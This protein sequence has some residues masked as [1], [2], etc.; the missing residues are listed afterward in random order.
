MDGF[1]S[2]PIQNNT[3]QSPLVSAANSNSLNSNDLVG[4]NAKDIEIVDEEKKE[5]VKNSFSFLLPLSILCLLAVFGYFGYLVFLRWSNLQQISLLSE[6][7]GVLSKNLNK[8][9]IDE[10]IVLDKS[11]KAI[12][13]RLA[14]HT[15]VSNILTFVNKNIRSN[16]QITDYRLESKVKDVIVSLSVI[17]P[18]F[19]ELAEQSEKMT[20]LKN[21]KE[22]KDFS[23]SQMA[24]EADGRRIRFNLN[25]TFEKKKL[26]DN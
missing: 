4:N 11:L 18:T 1:N 21:N 20:E 17:A 19:K 2:I 22:I 25:L 6:D 13:E 9:E 24:L 15:I 16:V 3:F 7:F 26:Y 23:V 5:V 12:K 14:G 10:F 8:D